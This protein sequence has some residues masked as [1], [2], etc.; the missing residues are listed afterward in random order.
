MIRIPIKATEGR[1]FTFYRIAKPIPH[2]LAAPDWE[3]LA[4]ATYS[5]GW[6]RAN[7]L[8]CALMG[9]AFVKKRF[10]SHKDVKN[11]SR[12]GLQFTIF[13]KGENQ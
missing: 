6:N 9:H 1:I 7:Y 10:G 3:V 11:G 2:T 13:P 8:L 5:L 4:F 12:Q